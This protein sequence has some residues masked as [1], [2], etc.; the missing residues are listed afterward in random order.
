MRVGELAE[1]TNT[2]LSRKGHRLQVSPETVGWKLRYLRFRTESIGSGGNGLWLLDDIRRR[3]HSLAGEYRVPLDPQGALQGC[4][5]CS[6]SMGE[7][8]FA[9]GE[10][11]KKSEDLSEVQRL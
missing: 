4:P 3:I 5:H 7:G 10:G 11:E 8:Q 2:I 6:N 1:A 9:G